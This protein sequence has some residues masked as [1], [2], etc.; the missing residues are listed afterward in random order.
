MV[1][2]GGCRGVRHP[3]GGPGGVGRG[4]G[5][6]GGQKLNDDLRHENAKNAVFARPPTPWGPWDPPTLP[7]H[8][9]FLAKNVKNHVFSRPI[10]AKVDMSPSDP[11]R[12]ITLLGRET[13][14]NAI[15]GEVIF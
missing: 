3:P 14:K 8:R 13:L 9:L 10:G 1:G 15:F 12:V 4:D 11:S 2:T 6:G 5:V 7:K